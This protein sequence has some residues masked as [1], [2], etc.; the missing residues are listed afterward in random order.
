MTALSFKVTHFVDDQPAS[1]VQAM[2]APTSCNSHAEKQ[3]ASEMRVKHHRDC[4]DIY[5]DENNSLS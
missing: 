5:D 1:R 4:Q 2:K 3:Q